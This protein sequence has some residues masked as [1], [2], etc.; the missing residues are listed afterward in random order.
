M[1]RGLFAS[2][3]SVKQQQWLHEPSLDPLYFERK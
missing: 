2:S 1:E 3:E